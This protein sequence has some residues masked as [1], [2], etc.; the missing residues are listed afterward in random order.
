MPVPAPPGIPALGES[1]VVPTAQEYHLQGPSSAQ[2][3]LIAMVHQRSQL[4]RGDRQHQG[5]QVGGLRIGCA[6][7]SECG[8]LLLLPSYK[9]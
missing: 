8:Q 6:Y 5:I 4:P 1:T 7:M 9:I 2:T 3:G